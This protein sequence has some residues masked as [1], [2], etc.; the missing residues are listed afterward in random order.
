[1]N[2]DRLRGIINTAYTPPPVQ[3]HLLSDSEL[4]ELIEKVLAERDKRLALLMANP[5]MKKYGMGPKPEL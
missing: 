2:D 5:L 4:A 1:M 3:V